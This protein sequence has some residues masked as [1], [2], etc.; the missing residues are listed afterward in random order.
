MADDISTAQY[1]SNADDET[2]HEIEDLVDEISA[3]SR[4]AVDPVEFYQHLL[5]RAVQSLA[6]LGGAAWIA[7]DGANES[8]WALAHQINLEQAHLSVDDVAPAS[9]ARLDKVAAEGDVCVNPPTSGGEHDSPLL[10][11]AAPVR[12]D[13]ETVAVI[14][15]FQRTQISPAA[16]RGYV[17]L[18]TILSELASD[19]HRNHQLMVF[20]ARNQRQ[21][22]LQEFS[23]SVHADLD[24]LTT[25]YRVANEGRRALQVDRVSVA[26][27][28]RNRAHI[29]VVSGL[30]QI[31]RR[32]NAVR[33]LERLIEVV[34]RHGEPF[35]YVGQREAIAPQ[36]ESLLQSYVDE[37]HARVLAIIPLSH[38]TQA[39]RTARTHS[40]LIVEHFD[41]D[42]DLQELRRDSA[43]LARI[44]SPALRHAMTIRDMPLRSLLFLLEP[45]RLRHLPKTL[46]V[47]IVAAVLIS[48]AIVV[49]ADFVIL[50]RG[51]LQPVERHDVFAPS[52]AQVDKLFAV[53][54]QEVEKGAVL[55]QLQYSKIEIDFN[56]V[57]G[58]IETNQQKLDAVNTNRILVRSENTAEAREKLNQLDAERRRLQVYLKNLNEELKLLKKQRQKLT[59]KSPIRGQVLTWNV[60]QRLDRRPV[61]R[62]QRLMT[63][64]NTKGPWELLIK[65]PDHHIGHIL[66]AQSELREDLQVSFVLGLDAGKVHQGKIESVAFATEVDE[67][68]G[69]S[70]QM[71]IR[72]D[73]EEIEH[74]RP[75]ASV[76]VRV[77]CGRRSIG[78]VWLH[79]LIDAVRTRWF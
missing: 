73:S 60:D 67:V 39:Q 68:E 38:K 26:T 28:K 3:H 27:W 77:H 2:W 63:V 34:V 30:D 44:A 13:A 72:I 61:Q 7:A 10:L 21:E 23:E 79:D 15:V 40:V 35:W 45:F 52:N 5:N 25:A 47:A 48:M 36:M 56:R 17:R 33:N 12:L 66:N 24:F 29:E 55:A 11:I 1:E 31:D 8:R 14:E 75:G 71:R 46:V 41:Q 54:A 9:Q 74:L 53:H 70:V 32:S 20:K 65:V 51:E 78:Y 62:G 64:V 18:L 49:P 22:S 76:V 16:Q 58:E 57:D 42:T 50:G 4:S 69:A 19:F 37:S 59:L 43:A 6:A